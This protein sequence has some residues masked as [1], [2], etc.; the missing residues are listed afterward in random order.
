MFITPEQAKKLTNKELA[1]DLIYR[2]QNIVESYIGKTESEIKSGKDKIL[3]GRAVAYQ[4]AYM[5]DNED[6]VYEQMAVT[7]SGS[8]T[9]FQ[10]I[11]REK[12]APWISPMAFLTLKGLSFKKSRSYRTGRIFQYA[13][14]SGW[15]S[16]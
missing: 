6:I 11:D 4:A 16:E 9:N 13:P 1:A 7:T 2:A 15:R 5:K 12:D 3:M 10:N 8:G 14:W